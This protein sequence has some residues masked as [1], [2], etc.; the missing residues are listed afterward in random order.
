MIGALQINDT[1]ALC[2]AHQACVM[3]RYLWMIKDDL[4]V[5]EPSDGDEGIAQGNGVDVGKHFLGCTCAIIEGECDQGPMRIAD[6]EDIPALEHLAKRLVASDD[7]SL[8]HQAIGGTWSGWMWMEQDKLVFIAHD[9]G[10]KAG[11][12]H[13]INHNI[14]ARI[15]SNIDD[16]F[17]QLIGPV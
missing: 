13:L 14:I 7:L 15:A 1:I 10:M 12:R 11:N 4:V 17:R 8:V 6:T 5:W 16:R 9:L 2:I 3:R